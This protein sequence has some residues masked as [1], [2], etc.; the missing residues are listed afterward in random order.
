MKPER[1]EEE[2]KRKIRETDRARKGFFILIAAWCIFAL[3]SA[4]IAEWENGTFVQFR[5]EKLPV[6]EETM[7]EAIRYSAWSW[8]QRTGIDIELRGTAAENIREGGIIFRW[9][10]QQH[11]VSMGLPAVNAYTRRWIYSDTQL[12]Y[13]YEVVLNLQ[14]F[15]GLEVSN[16]RTIMHEMGHALGIREHSA[17]RHSVMSIPVISEPARYAL[18]TVDIV[19]V[20]GVAVIER[21]SLC[22]AELTRELDIYIPDI[23]GKRASLKYMGD[24]LWKLQ[25]VSENPQSSNCNS[26]AVDPQTLT[27]HINDLRSLEV[28]YQAILDYTGNDMWKLRWAQ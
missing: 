26:T 20:P 12:T 8:A 18:S 22:H 21:G 23:Q 10:P 13:G 19:N 17:D 27:L 1:Y 5:T 2:L 16:M 4:G 6:S 15:K 11:F 7:R 24:Q 28:T 3:V 25:S 9:E 14:S